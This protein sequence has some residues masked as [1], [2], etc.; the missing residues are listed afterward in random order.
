MRRVY[1]CWDMSL[2]IYI[3][4]YYPRFSVRPHPSPPMISTDIAGLIGFACESVLYGKLRLFQLFSRILNYLGA[5]AVIF[6]LSLVFLSWRRRTHAMSYP[7]ILS[8]CLPFV[9]CTVHYA[10]EFNHFY[11]SLVCSKVMRAF[12]LT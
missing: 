4:H 10:L 8:T 7:M 1:S 6:I 11:N 12:R 2:G 9:L 5:F 3:L